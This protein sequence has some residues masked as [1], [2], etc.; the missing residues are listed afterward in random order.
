MLRRQTAYNIQNMGKDED[1]EASSRVRLVLGGSRYYLG[2]DTAEY[3]C[4]SSVY[5]TMHTGRI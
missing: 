1:N 2:I 4:G 3:I 5:H